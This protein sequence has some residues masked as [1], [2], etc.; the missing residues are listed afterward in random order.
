M[1]TSSNV[2]LQNFSQVDVW[3]LT[4]P[5]QNLDYFLFQ[6]FVALVNFS[7]ALAVRQMA[8]LGPVVSKK[9]KSSPLL[10]TMF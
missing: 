2:Q 6:S 8:C 3:T 5:L 4:E 9:A 7:Q 10:T 1:R